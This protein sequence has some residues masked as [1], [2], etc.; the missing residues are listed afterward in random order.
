MEPSKAAGAVRNGVGRLQGAVCVHADQ[1]DGPAVRGRNGV[2]GVPHAKGVDSL[3]SAEPVKAAFAVPGRVGRL[4]GAV[5][6]YADQL[7]GI[8]A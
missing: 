3:E 4:Q 7:D 5:A 1:M 6:V 2:R 8:V